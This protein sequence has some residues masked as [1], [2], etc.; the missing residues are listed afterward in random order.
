MMSQV[1]NGDI[2]TDCNPGR[3]RTCG[4]GTLQVPENGI[5]LK[6]DSNS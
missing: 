4:T 5:T 3:N 6:M 1:A 2:I